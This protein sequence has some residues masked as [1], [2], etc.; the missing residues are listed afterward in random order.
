MQ[1]GEDEISCP[2]GSPFGFGEV[3]IRCRC[4][5][6]GNELVPIVYGYYNGDKSEIDGKSVFGDAQ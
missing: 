1:I 6:C 3:E 2:P 4:P 5:I